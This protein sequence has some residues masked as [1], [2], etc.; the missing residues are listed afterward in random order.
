LKALVAERSALPE[1]EVLALALQMVS[2]L[3]YLHGLSPPMVH[4]D[5]TPDNLLLTERGVL[6]L[7]DFN[8]AKERQ[9]TK[10]ALVVGKHAYMPPEQFKGKV[11]PQSDIY[12]LGASLHFLLTGTD[13]EPLSCCHP[14]QQNERVSEQMDAIVAKATSLE[15]ADRYLDVAALH[16]DLTE[17]AGM[18]E[19]ETTGAQA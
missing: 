9:N 4:Q 18:R 10:T 12:A 19:R 14:A 1:S 11:C 6:K 17:L 7:V 15:L 2:V 16:K 3:A 13:P 8:V 5:F